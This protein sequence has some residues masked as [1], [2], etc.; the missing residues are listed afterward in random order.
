MHRRDRWLAAVLAAAVLSLA[1]CAAGAESFE[2]ATSESRAAKVVPIEGT[3][4]SR[5]ELT[6]EAAKRLGIQTEPVRAL[7]VTVAGTRAGTS[8][9]LAIPVAGVLYDEAGDTW[10]YT[11][12]QPLSFVRQ[13]IAVARIDGDLA[14]LSSG[15]APGTAVVTVGAAE[16]LGAEYKVDGD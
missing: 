13:P 1:G 8:P 3:D 11:T 15:P 5:V 7:P 10:A 16:L 9:R 14:L 12:L 4:L 2:E 6:A